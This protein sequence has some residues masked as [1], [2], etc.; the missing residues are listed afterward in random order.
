MDD[1]TKTRT[2]RDIQMG[3]DGHIY[4]VEWRPARQRPEKRQ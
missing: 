2:Y 1:Q 3:R 4:R